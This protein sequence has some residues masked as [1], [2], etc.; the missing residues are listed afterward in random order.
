[1]LIN[2]I[3]LM[4][5][6][7]VFSGCA[8]SSVSSQTSAVLEPQQKDSEQAVNDSAKETVTGM[9]NSPVVDFEIPVMYPGILVDR[10][11]YVSDGDKQ[12]VILAETLP[13][14]FRVINKT[15]GEVVYEGSVKSTEYEIDGKLSALADF[16]SIKEPGEYYIETEILGGSMDFAVSDSVYEDLLTDTFLRL[17]GMRCE[18][19]SAIPYENNPTVYESKSGGWY[20]ND[21]QE[22]DVV[23]GCL[24]IIDLTLAYEYHPKSFSDKMGIAESKNKI[25]DIL[26]EAKYEAEWL[27]KM[28]NSETGGVYNGISLRQSPGSTEKQ[29]MIVGESSKS[30]AY[31]CAALAKFSL[32]YNK[33]DKNFASKCLKAAT[34]A[35]SCLKTNKNVV[36][37]AQ[38]YRAAVEMYNATGKDEYREVIEQYLEKN[39]G[40]VLESR[41]AVDAA[42]S[43]MA[44]AEATD[45]KAC[46]KL[47]S[48]FLDRTQEK[49]SLSKT[50]PFGI[51]APELSPGDLLRNADEL[52]IV[53]YINTSRQYENNEIAYLHYLCGRNVISTVYVKEFTN[54]DDCAKLLFLLGR[55]MD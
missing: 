6:M 17:H 15:T 45:V 42:I 28:Q 48:A 22:R 25:P 40:Q 46:R 35:W 1:M 5:L 24:G 9:L 2:L 51:E 10:V 47:M 33:Y 7:L 18:D 49:T 11:G 12:A 14:N 43:Y 21:N 44:S 13:A 26:D 8:D 52:V 41:G 38:M 30:T 36:S 27:L 50:N 20:T 3:L 4:A 55:L 54:P 34:K 23:E 31:F 32:A 39:A 19:A 29:L 53:D 16:S 37:D